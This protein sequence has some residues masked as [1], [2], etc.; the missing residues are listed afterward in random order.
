MTCPMSL[1][2]QLSLSDGG[3]VVRFGLVLDAN[4]FKELAGCKMFQFRRHIQDS[5]VLSL[6][7]DETTSDLALRSVLCF[8]FRMNNRAYLAFIIKQYVNF[9]SPSFMFWGA[10]RPAGGLIDN[11][12]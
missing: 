3:E 8:N 5:H 7:Y 1:Q 11:R 10:T 12:C 4:R 6:A 9:H 2:R